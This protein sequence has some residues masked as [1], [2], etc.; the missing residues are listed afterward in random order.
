MN[1]RKLRLDA[2]I[3]PASVAW[4]DDSVEPHHHTGHNEAAWLIALILAL[5]HEMVVR[6]GVDGCDST[7]LHEEAC[8]E[9]ALYYVTIPMAIRQ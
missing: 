8:A 2:A 1:S 9:V 3:G 7:N 4:F 5:Y 6:V